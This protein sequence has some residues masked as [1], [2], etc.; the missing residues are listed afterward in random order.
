MFKLFEQLI[1]PFPV[2]EPTK[3]PTTLLAFCYHYT[4]DIKWQLAIMALLTGLL[5]VVE[6]SLFSFL[7]QLV[8][9]LSEK[10]PETFLAEEGATLL[11]MGLIILVILPL[12]V[13]AHSTIVHQTLQGNYPMVI[14]WQAHRYLLGQSLSFFQNDKDV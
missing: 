5:G 7:G 11:W 12:L 14:R 3:P 13:L 8:D 2:K 4:R 9:W 1:D 6:V 10:Q